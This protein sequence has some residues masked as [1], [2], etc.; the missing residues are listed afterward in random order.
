MYTQY[1]DIDNPL[2]SLNLS[3]GR[4]GSNW[5]VMEN[6]LLGPIFMLLPARFC[7]LNSRGNGGAESAVTLKEF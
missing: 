1:R 6:Q 4:L 5:L 7:T 2:L 3:V